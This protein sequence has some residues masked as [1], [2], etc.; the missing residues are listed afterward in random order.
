MDTL[1]KEIRNQI[2]YFVLE[3]PIAT[4]YKNNVDVKISIEDNKTLIE[5]IVS[6][7][8]L[9]YN[10]IISDDSTEY[11]G[12]LTITIEPSKDSINKLIIDR[13][14][15]FVTEAE[16]IEF[17]EKSKLIALKSFRKYKI[18]ITTKRN[19]KYEMKIH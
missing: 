16:I 18:L 15:V 4:I 9:I 14:P 12:K 1:P 2:K 5:I 13:L 17:F 8:K 6:D 3:H 19:I 11:F 7:K 10:A